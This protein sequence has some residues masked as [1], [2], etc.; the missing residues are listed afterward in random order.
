MDDFVARFDPHNPKHLKAYM[1]WEWGGED[2][3][4]NF[5]PSPE[6]DNSFTFMRLRIVLAQCWCEEKLKGEVKRCRQ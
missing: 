5:K 4:E 6:Q 1:D 3:P 2:W